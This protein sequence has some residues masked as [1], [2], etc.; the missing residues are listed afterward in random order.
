M[1]KRKPKPDL[2]PSYA[3]YLINIIQ[4]TKCAVIATLDEDPIQVWDCLE[5]VR[6]D[7]AIIQYLTSSKIEAKP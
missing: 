5:Q 4:Q 1:T 3:S 2:F 7:E 6:N